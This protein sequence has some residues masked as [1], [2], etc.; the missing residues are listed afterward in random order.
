MKQ[1]KL[2]SVQIKLRNKFQ[3][4]GVKM[5]APDTVFFSEN[6]KIGTNVTI[7]P[8]VVIADNVSI[9]NNV[10]ILSFS[11]LEG[12]KIENNVNVGPYA[13][14]RPGTILK[15]GS[16]VGNFVEIKKSIIG[17]SSKINHLSYVG[18]TKIGEKVNIGAGTITCNYDGIKK[19]KTIIDDGV[20]VGSNS[21][22]V[23]PIKL[24]KKSIIG[25]G[26]VITKKVSKNS[27]AITRAEQ[28]E[29]KNYKRKK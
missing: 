4:K 18:D 12:V 26:S 22:L 7:E 20:F 9:G 6:T 29:K 23:A 11:H 13:R 19:N 10:K 28:I 3:K 17:K 21:S 1:K 15:S 27:L 16:K 8:Y 5:I 24:E 25:A 14:L 2:I